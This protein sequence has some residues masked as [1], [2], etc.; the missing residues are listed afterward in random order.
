MTKCPAASLNTSA[1]A[2][3][4]EKSL[5]PAASLISTASTASDIQ[6]VMPWKY[7]HTH[8]SQQEIYTNSSA[9]AGHLSAQSC[10]FLSGNPY[11][12]YT[13]NIAAG[14]F[15][16]GMDMNRMR[17]RQEFSLTPQI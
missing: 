13:N 5:F 12:Y 16:N 1:R 17:Y 4:V 6:Y 10:N 3:S 9:I 7:T 2:E 8:Y 11:N 14:G 15:C